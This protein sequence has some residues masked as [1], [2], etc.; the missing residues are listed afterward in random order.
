MSVFRRQSSLSDGTFLVI[1]DSL[2]AIYHISRT[3]SYSFNQ[4]ESEWIIFWSPRIDG[5][6]LFVQVE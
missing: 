4:A 5:T 1:R 2:T 3:G 6:R